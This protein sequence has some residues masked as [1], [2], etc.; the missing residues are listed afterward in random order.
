M[1]RREPVHL[2]E[3]V[4]DL[5]RRTREESVDPLRRIE[6]AWSELAARMEGAGDTRVA[7][8]SRGVV[9]VEVKSPPLCAEVAQFRRLRVLADLRAAVGES[10]RVKDVRFRLGA[11]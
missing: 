1:N 8:F 9:S 11:W 5:V 7:G 2:G 6:A 10:V 3:I 4:E